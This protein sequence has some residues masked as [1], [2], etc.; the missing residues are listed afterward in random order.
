MDH[1]IDEY[2]QYYRDVCAAE[3][4]T[5]INFIARKLIGIIKRTLSSRKYRIEEPLVT[6]G[7]LHKRLT[8]GQALILF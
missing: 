3:F 1:G 2:I 6:E 8:I 7:F 5:V 4:N